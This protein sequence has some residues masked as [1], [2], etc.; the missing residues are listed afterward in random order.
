MSRRIRSE[1]QEFGSDSFLDVIANVVGI[2]I[3]L[4]MVV[5]MRIKDTPLPKRP[6][7]EIVDLSA[8]AHEARS[9]ERGTFQLAAQIRSLTLEGLKQ[10]QRHDE[11]AEQLVARQGELERQRQKLDAEADEQ[12][13]V[14]RELLSA[15][16]LAQQLE[17]DI[18]RIADSKRA[19]TIESFPT[20]IAKAVDGKEVHFQ[21]RAG[22]VTYIPLEEL[23]KLLKADA[24]SQFWK[25]KDL[26][27]ATA[28]VGPVGGFRLKYTFER[29]DVPLEDQLAGKRMI[30]SIAQLSQWTL[31]PS[32]NLLGET[33]E[34]ALSE[35]SEFRTILG[36]LNPRQTTITL[37]VYPDSFGLFRAVRKELYH[38]EFA[39]A[40]RPLPDDAPIGGS[41]H[42]SKSAA[43]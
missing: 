19:I 37:W 41:P 9:L 35:G 12:F 28:S 22:R 30:S 8:A 13:M 42:G 14:Q 27:E 7:A 43:Q 32:D 17:H 21:L 26:P 40:A 18:K 29:I 5:G 20:P 24:P 36:K 25:L 16:T 2:L 10:Q 39:A 11:L 1:E 15:Q 31:V 4:V 34:V 23:L 6:I 33:A 3:I 38:A